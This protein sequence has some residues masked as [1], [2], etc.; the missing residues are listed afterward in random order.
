MRRETEIEETIGIFYHIL[1]IGGILIWG[2]G[3]LGPLWLR[4]WLHM[5]LVITIRILYIFLLMSCAKSSFVNARCFRFFI[6]LRAMES[7]SCFFIFANSSPRVVA[8]F[9]IRFTWLFYQIYV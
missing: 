6:S 2:A 7:T 4:L 1:F 5:F 8:N 3:L 9:S